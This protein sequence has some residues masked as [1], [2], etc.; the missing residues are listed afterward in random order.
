MSLAIIGGEKRKYLH[1]PVAGLA[2]GWRRGRLT[3][4]DVQDALSASRTSNSP[5]GGSRTWIAS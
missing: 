5:A 3:V 2:S 1:A 4:L